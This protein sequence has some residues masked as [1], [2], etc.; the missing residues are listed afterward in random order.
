MFELY[1]AEGCGDSALVRE[2]PTDLG[3]SCVVHHPRSAA[4]ETRPDQP[5]DQ[6]LSLGGDSLIPVVADRERG[7]TMYDSE[8]IV[9]YL[10]EHYG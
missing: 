5:H 3:I 6:L 7:V 2:T 1:H 10:E 9:D 8:D 4:G